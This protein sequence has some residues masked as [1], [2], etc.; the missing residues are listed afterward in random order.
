MIT[1]TM[2][3]GAYVAH[4]AIPYLIGIA[5]GVAAIWASKSQKPS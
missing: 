5:T 1:V 3:F 2:S 4:A